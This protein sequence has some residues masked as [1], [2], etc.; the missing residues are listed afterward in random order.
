MAVI[1][2]L[3]VFLLPSAFSLSITT[4][5]CSNST[6]VGLFGLDEPP[7]CKVPK[8]NTPPVIIDY[9]LFVS[10]K[11]VIK[12]KGF[13]CFQ[14]IKTKN[15]VGYFFGGYDT[16]FSETVLEVSPDTCWQLALS[17]LCNG[18]KM[19]VDNN[20][21][22]FIGS[23]DGKKI[24]FSDVSYSVT[25]CIVRQIELKKDCPTC[26]VTSPSLGLLSNDSEVNFNIHNHRTIVW[27]NPPTVDQSSCTLKNLQ[28]GSGKLTQFDNQSFRILDSE[29]QLEFI[30]SKSKVSTCQQPNF[31][32][33]RTIPNAYLKFENRTSNSFRH[34]TGVPISIQSI[35][36]GFCL[37]VQTFPAEKHSRVYDQL[38]ASSCEIPKI[39][40]HLDTENRLRINN[41]CISF[42][43]K[44]SD[45]RAGIMPLVYDLETRSFRSKDKCLS[46]NDTSL[47]LS[48][49]TNADKWFLTQNSTIDGSLSLLIEHHQ[50]MEFETL[51]RENILAMEIQHSYC[52]TIRTKRLD[53]LQLSEHDGLRAAKASHLPTCHTITAISD[54]FI[55]H[56]CL[57]FTSEVGSV[58][59]KC[60]FQ[61]TVHNTFSIAKDGYS[62]IDF[63]PCVWQHGIV[64][65]NDVLYEYRNNDWFPI[66]LEMLHSDLRLIS[67]FNESMDIEFLYVPKTH[68]SET[69]TNVNELA[70][71]A[72]LLT[73]ASFETK[74][75]SNQTQ[76]IR[77]TE[78]AFSIFSNDFSFS[79]TSTVAYYIFG[80]IS[81]MIVASV[82][83]LFI[84]FWNTIFNTCNNFLIQPQIVISTPVAPPVE[85]VDPSV[86]FDDCPPLYESLPGISPQ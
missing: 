69:P 21:R 54:K 75:T 8:V 15:I 45:C 71:V 67:Q 62:R 2:L 43:F 37:T 17:N 59:T 48:S 31:H 7:Y 4:C 39:I 46:V 13:I 30:I 3:T 61:P 44:I 81:L 76:I 11:P 79:S 9:D 83:L 14:W 29:G 74:G 85:N 63:S 23:P 6:V 49:C 70:E 73:S 80:F 33:I 20:E 34:F 26:P 5:D 16:T 60:G 41:S 32:P 18:N 52:E 50:Y 35:S 40:F 64:N 1:I 77:S 82:V 51:T 57:N 10:E 72:G 47:I 65:L 19:S 58:K 42:N 53:L 56:K 22:S 78:T 36:S 27:N 12:F 68:P 25:N 84:K 66:H 28:S 55:V 86:N 24:W 38:I